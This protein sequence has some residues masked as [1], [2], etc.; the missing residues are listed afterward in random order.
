MVP[1]SIEETDKLF[2]VKKKA[3]IMLTIKNKD[4]ESSKAFVAKIEAA[5]GKKILFPGTVNGSIDPA[6]AKTPVTVIGTDGI[7]YDN[8]AS[9]KSPI[10]L[11]LAQIKKTG[12]LVIIDEKMQPFDR[13]ESLNGLS[14][15]IIAD[16]AFMSKAD[17]VAKYGDKGNKGAVLITTTFFKKRH[18]N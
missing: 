4:T 18:I 14:G 10:I 15:E 13:L 6:L 12:V 9:D 2:G 1:L 5:T 3:G 11:N 17:A 8:D 7:I 16:V